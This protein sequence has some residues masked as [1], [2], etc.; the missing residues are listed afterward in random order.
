MP[1]D[2]IVFVLLE[3][4]AD[5]EYG[6]LAGELADPQVDHP[7]FDVRYAS[8]TLDLKTSIGGMRMQS[9]ITLEQIPQDAAALVLIGGTSWKLPVAQAVAPIA[10][11]FLQEG[12][13][14]AAICDAARF[15]GANGLLNAH[16]HTLNFAEDTAGEALYR[17]AAG[18][19]PEEAV[20][21]RNLV[22]ANGNAPYV[23]AR[24][25]LRALGTPEA[26]AVKWY[27]FYTLGFHKA[28]AKYYPNN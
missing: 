1:K 12:K 4:F 8:D 23:F 15:L 17:N 11:R 18:Y 6:P 13:V 26:E 25:V 21:D 20:R 2:T 27:E 7:A 16:Q 14:L 9:D 22:T 3:G 10:E 19:R 5:W 28:I 24:E